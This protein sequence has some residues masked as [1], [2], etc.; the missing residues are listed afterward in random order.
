MLSKRCQYNHWYTAIGRTTCTGR[1]P[2][3]LNC[4]L[5]Q[6]RYL[7]IWCRKSFLICLI[8]TVVWI[9]AEEIPVRKINISIVDIFSQD[10]ESSIFVKIICIGIGLRN[11]HFLCDLNPITLAREAFLVSSWPPLQRRLFSFTIESSQKERIPA[12]DCFVW[13]RG[14][15]SARIPMR[16]WVYLFFSF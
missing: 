10:W 8:E 4:L 14:S 5:G 15:H 7:P 11:I 12:D 2:L 16:L 6:F 3:F 9:L 1:W 13:R